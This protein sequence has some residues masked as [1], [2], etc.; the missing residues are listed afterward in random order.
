MRAD[1]PL[2]DYGDDQLRAELSRIYDERFELGAD[3]KLRR[4]ILKGLDADLQLVLHEIALRERRRA[5][6]GPHADI[7]APPATASAPVDAPR[8]NGVS[9]PAQTD[10]SSH[11][12]TVAK[13]C[14]YCGAPATLRTVTGRL[15]CERDAETHYGSAKGSIEVLAT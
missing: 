6:P 8:S 11:N 12:G 15:L 3:M 9:P 5:E 14:Y 2:C 7:E 1:K 4:A 13:P 10:A